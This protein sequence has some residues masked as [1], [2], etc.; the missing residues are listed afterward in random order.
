MLRRN[1]T[2]FIRSCWL[3]LSLCLELT[4]FAAG[5]LRHRGA[6]KPAPPLVKERRSLPTAALINSKRYSCARRIGGWRAFNCCP[7]AG[8][9]RQ[10]GGSRMHHP[11][12]LREPRAP[13]SWRYC[14]P[15]RYCHDGNTPTGPPARGAPPLLAPRK[16]REMAV[17]LGGLRREGPWAG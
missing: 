11:P 5:H 13:P 12:G 1:Q 16:T 15:A 3:V 8:T 6:R 2:W 4:G 14:R 17:G 9:R 10:A 7:L